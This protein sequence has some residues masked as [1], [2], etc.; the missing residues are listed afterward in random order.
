MEIGSSHVFKC[1]FFFFFGRGQA[2]GVY[3][4]YQTYMPQIEDTNH[5]MVNE[6][7]EKKMQPGS[8][9]SEEM[10]GMEVDNGKA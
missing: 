2:Q 1:V 6:E 10:V 8:E 5:D 3:E 7:A 9:G 4:Q